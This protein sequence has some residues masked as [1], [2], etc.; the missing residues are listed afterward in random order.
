MILKKQMKVR[1]ST[2]TIN[3][4]IVKIQLCNNKQNKKL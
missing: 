1:K 2:Q 3:K 4:I